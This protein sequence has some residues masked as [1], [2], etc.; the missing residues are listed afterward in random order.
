MNWWHVYIEIALG[1]AI[2]SVVCTW[3]A[4]RVAPTLGF[5]D[6][7]GAEAHKRHVRATP[8]L[9]GA[10]MFLA[11]A[12]TVVSGLLLSAAGRRIVAP[13]VAAYLPGVQTVLPQLASIVLGA[14]ALVVLG[15]FDDKQRLD[16]LTKLIGQFCVAGATACW[17]NIRI[18]L[19]IDHP[20]CTWALTTL[21]IL[22]VINAIN[23]FDNMDGLA[24][25][26]AAVAAFFFMFVAGLRHQYFV[27]ALGASVW[28]AAAGFLVFNH[29]PATIFM[30]D[31]GSHFLGYVLAVTG[32]LTTFYTPAEGAL[33]GPHSPTLAPLLIPPLVLAIPLFD[34]A[35]VV[36]IRLRAGRPVYVGDHLHMSHRFVRLGL[37][38][39]KAVLVVHLLS[40]VSGAAAVALLWLPPAGVVFVLLQIAAVLAVVS[41]LHTVGENGDGPTAASD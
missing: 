6:H 7:P 22:C 37:S 25:G 15:L 34:L 11:W 16:P 35:A 9:G 36:F 30:G 14:A 31:A 28:G 1:S 2:L 38:R 10:G 40:F 18:T 39:G 29:P 3:L 8:V 23:F 19:F 24:A 4:R 27:A 12:I 26:A 5:V 41:I 21:W 32:V 33:A 13:E 20:L 17:G